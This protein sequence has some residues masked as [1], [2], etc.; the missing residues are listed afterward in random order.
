MKKINQDSVIM[1]LRNLLVRCMCVLVI[2]LLM[3]IFSKKSSLYKDFI[4]SNVYETNISFARINKLY[5]KYLGGVFPFNHNNNF[6]PV[7]KE[8]LEYDNLS[9]FHDGVK[10]SVIDNYLV[11]SLSGGMIT[12]IGEKENYG[13]VIIVTTEDDVNIWYGNIKRSAVKLYD[14]VSIGNYLGEVDGNIL[15]LVF[16]KDKKYLDY[17]EFIDES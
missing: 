13:N 9:L 14:Y 2:F 17:K 4:I 3:L 12:Y 5:D 10:L 11:P 6:V 8:N 15:Y 1:Y 16:S 7:F